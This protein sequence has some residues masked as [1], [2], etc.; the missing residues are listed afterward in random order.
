[1]RWR[2]DW[3]GGGLLGSSEWGILDTLFVDPS[4]LEVWERSVKEE[5]SENLMSL[6]TNLRF[7]RQKVLKIEAIFH[8]HYTLSTKK[9]EEIRR[10]TTRTKYRKRNKTFWKLALVTPERSS[11]FFLRTLPYHPKSLP[12]TIRSSEIK[13]KKE[14]NSIENFPSLYGIILFEPFFIYNSSHPV[15][16]PSLETLSRT[17]RFFNLFLD[18]EL[19][20]TMKSFVYSFRSFR[21]S[22]FF[23]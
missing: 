21:D 7:A 16:F 15:F 22:S 6:N 9:L 10:K 2:N 19:N 1:M 12:S 3:R 18:W 5:E 14:T 11:S 17:V 20:L 8:V 13:Q 4:A 23:R